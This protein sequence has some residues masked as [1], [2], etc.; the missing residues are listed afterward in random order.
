MDNNYLSIEIQ[1]RLIEELTSTN[2]ELKLIN[3]FAT[4]IHESKSTNDIVLNLYKYF[5]S[6]FGFNNCNIYLSKEEHEIQAFYKVKGNETNDQEL[7]CQ[8]VPFGDIEP[9]VDKVATSK[10]P[11]KYK[12]ISNSDNSEHGFG[13]TYSKIGIPMLHHEEEVI[14]VMVF[15]HTIHDFFQ[16]SQIKTLSTI[17]AIAATKIIQTQHFE[18]IERYQSQ[19]EEYVHIVSHDLKSPLRS[20]NALVHWI[21]ED[22]E[23]SLDVETLKNLNLIDGILMHMDNLIARTLNYSKLDYE[24]SSE[25]KVDCQILVQELIKTIYIPEHIKVNIDSKLPICIGDRT[26][27][28]Q[29]F[30]NLIEN[31]IKFIDKPKGTI[32][33]NVNEAPK[34]HVFSIKDNGVGINEKYH[35]KI[36]EIFQ[37]LSTKKVS[38]GV[39]L[40]IVKKLVSFYDGRIWLESTEGLGSTFYFSLKK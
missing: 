15:E 40:S 25:E 1:N 10:S 7:F 11:E 39:G 4:L 18:K 38:S 26:K 23:S 29:I 6:H 27:F 19:L 8:K 32:N 30:Q 13:T 12:T 33:I 9:I 2:R 21:K 35:H 24:N 16:E 22:N 28:T 31:A 5:K 20:I 37:S 36:F 14:G 3:T 17:A 34:H